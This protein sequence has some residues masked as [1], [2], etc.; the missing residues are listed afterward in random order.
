MKKNDSDG[1][2]YKD[3]YVKP[4][5]FSKCILGKNFLYPDANE[6]TDYKIENYYCPDTKELHI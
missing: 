4:I 2:I 1:S 3:H 5:P 6:L